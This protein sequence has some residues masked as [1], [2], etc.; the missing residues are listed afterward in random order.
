[1][2]DLFLLGLAALLVWVSLQAFTLQRRLRESAEEI[3]WLRQLVENAE[4]R[5]ADLLNVNYELAVLNEDLFVALD[6][7]KPLAS[8]LSC[9]ANRN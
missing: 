8:L 9:A 4:Q 1:M 2:F 3:Q 6:H 7:R 5:N